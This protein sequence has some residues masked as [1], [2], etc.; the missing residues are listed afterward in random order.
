[1]TRATTAQPSPRR[2]ASPTR[3]GEGWVIR[4]WKPSGLLPDASCGRTS[5]Y[6]CDRKGRMVWGAKDPPV[7]GSASLDWGLAEWHPVGCCGEGY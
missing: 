7:F 3:E 5:R 1:M 2:Q 4:P 6:E